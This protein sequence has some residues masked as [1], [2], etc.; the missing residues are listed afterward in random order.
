MKWTRRL[1][2]RLGIMRDLFG[3]LW[4]QRLWWMIPMITILLLFGLLLIF[5][6]S[7]PLAPFVY[8][9]F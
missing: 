3:F 1:S 6:Q 7:S 2:S 9:L 8:T 4:R 5:A